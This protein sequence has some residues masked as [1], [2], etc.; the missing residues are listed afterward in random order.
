MLQSAKCCHPLSVD[1]RHVDPENTQQRVCSVFDPSSAPIGGPAHPLGN[2]EG[3]Q[4][5]TPDIQDGT[6]NT[7]YFAD[8]QREIFSGAYFCPAPRYKE[9]G[10][11]SDEFLE[12]PT[13][14]EPP[15]LSKW[16]GSQSRGGSP[17]GPHVIGD[18][19][20]VGYADLSVTVPRVHGVDGLGELDAAR[21]VDTACVDPQPVVTALNGKLAAIADLWNKGPNNMT[22]WLFAAG[23]T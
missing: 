5:F 21:V 4:C 1:S 15:T 13:A 6:G 11:G 22:R 2:T 20:E 12:G 10:A 19:G 9:H 17:F 14:R 3:G 7:C 23:V 18:I 16:A 8:I